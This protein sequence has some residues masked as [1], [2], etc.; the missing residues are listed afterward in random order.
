MIFL[1]FFSFFIRV[2]NLLCTILAIFMFII[3]K[4][5]ISNSTYLLRNQS[6]ISFIKRLYSPSRSILRLSETDCRISFWNFVESASP[7]AHPRLI[8]RL[9]DRV[10]DPLKLGDCSWL[11]QGV[12]ENGQEAEGQC[13]EATYNDFA[14][15]TWSSEKHHHKTV[16]SFWWRKETRHP[17]CSSKIFENQYFF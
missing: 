8:I 17:G 15:R 7:S 5:K 10:S 6:Q 12:H 2:H 14:W 9:N 11:D 1:I 3:Q 4:F 13:Q 16:R